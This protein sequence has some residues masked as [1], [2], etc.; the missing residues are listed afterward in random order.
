[1]SRFYVP[2]EAVAGNKITITGDEAHHIKDVMRLKVSDPVVAFDGTGREYTGAISRIDPK[3]VVVDIIK[4]RESAGG[5]I[6]SLTLIQAIPKKDKMDY[7]VEKATELGVSRIVPV[8]TERTI[9]DWDQKKRAASVERWKRISLAA[10]KQCGRL[11]IPAIDEVDEFLPFLKKPSGHGLAMIAALCD[12]QVSLKDV[13][14]GYVGTNVTIAIGP[15]GDF[16]QKEIDAARSQCY[17]VVSLGGRVLRS[18]TAGLAVLSILNY[19][20]SE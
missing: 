12:D 14:R 2:K 18:D 10:S 6:L 20:F 13:I 4:T 9:V 11:D 7:I 15:E 5:K 16:T 8:M 3:S 17:K 1:M 19:E